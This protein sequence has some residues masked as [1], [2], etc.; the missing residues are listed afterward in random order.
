VQATP[1]S[2]R[3]DPEARDALSCAAETAQRTVSGLAADLIR[4]GLAADTNP[5]GGAPD[6][7]HPLVVTVSDMFAE[8][9]GPDVPAQRE[10]AMVLARVAA[11]GGAPA[12]SAVKELRAIF[13]ELEHLLAY[14]GA[15]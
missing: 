9:V 15:A 7:E 5:A 6:T 12:V 10:A 4:A 8:V 2:L 14:R 11:A 13:A 3:L 1:L